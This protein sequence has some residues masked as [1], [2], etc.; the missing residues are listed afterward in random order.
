MTLRLRGPALLA[1]LLVLALA[2]CGGAANAP[3]PTPIVTVGLVPTLTGQFLATTTNGSV[4]TV[5]LFAVNHTTD[6][7]MTG[8]LHL[9]IADSATGQKNSGRF[10][11]AGT[12][13]GQTATLTISTSATTADPGTLIAEG[14]GAQFTIV[15]HSGTVSGVAVAA[16][17]PQYQQQCAAIGIPNAQ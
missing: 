15:E 16:T 13:N 10:A 7:R 11:I 12:V 6:R 17:L 14:T 1:G 5:Y 4:T 2:G 3:A 9:C 8:I